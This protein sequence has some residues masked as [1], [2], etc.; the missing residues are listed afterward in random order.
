MSESPT[1]PPSPPDLSTT[2]SEVPRSG[3]EVANL[4]LRMGALVDEFKTSDGHP[5]LVLPGY[6]GSDA[7]MYFLRTFLERVGYQT[8]RLKLGVNYESSEQRIMSVDDAVRFREFMVARV[9]KRVVELF[10]Q[11][12]EKISMIGWSMGGLYA[13]DVAKELQEQT[14]M[15]ITLGSPF[16]DPRSTSLFHA[17]RWFNGSSVPIEGQDFAGWTSRAN[18]GASKVPVKVIYSEQDGIVGTGIARPPAH[19]SIDCIEVS[20]SHIGFAANLNAFRAVAKQLSL[21][22]E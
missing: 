14:R 4:L 20:S 8:C 19:P 16:G 12:G 22:T 15:V 21:V 7:A 6:G 10:E 2:L 1:S 5:V 9:K 18:A 17:L 11:H 3:F 13:F